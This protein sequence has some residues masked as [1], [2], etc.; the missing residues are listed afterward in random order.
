MV[1]PLGAQIAPMWVLRTPQI[2]GLFTADRDQPHGKSRSANGQ[3]ARPPLH[4]TAAATHLARAMEKLRLVLVED[5]VDLAFVTET[6]LE[7]EG[8][9]VEVAHDGR[10]GLDLIDRVHP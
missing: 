10:A 9:D 4:P 8:L 6:A 7:L 5:D 1:S 3:R 2:S